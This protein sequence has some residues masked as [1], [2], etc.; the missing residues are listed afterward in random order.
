MAA[1]DEDLVTA[2]RALDTLVTADLDGLG[3]DDLNAGVLALQG[4]RCQVEAAEARLL[5]RWDANR[6][7]QPDGAKTGAAWLAWKQHLPITEARRR[8]RHARALRD[9]PAIEQAWAAGEIDRTHL[10]TMFSKRTPRTREAFAREHEVLLDAAR[11][12]RFTEFKRRCDRWELTVDP[13]G[14]EQGADADRR[15]RE[16]HLSQSFQGMWFGRMTFDP[17]SG[18]ILDTTLKMI[19]RELFDADS[20]DAR[21]RLGR[22][23][24][25]TELARTPAQRRAD[26][27]VEMAIRARTAPADGRRPAPLF[28]IVCGLESFTGPI[29]ELFNRTLLT[30][31][32]A[33]RWLT[34]ADV[35]RIVFS[36]PSRVID[37]STT[38]RFFRG[39]LR[40]AIEV[41]DRTC[42]HPSC[43]EIPDRQHIDHIHEAAKGGPTTQTNG[44]PACAFHNLRR[45]HHPDPD[46][47]EPG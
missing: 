23:P 33:A 24:L 32:V 1:L 7:W 42:F 5:S 4:L 19:E 11:S 46:D 3:S 43:D 16:V 37:V 25:V 2:S 21:Q 36:S 39:A 12:Q 40:R 9:L 8:L 34:E 27:L 38:T 22:D 45:N 6:C 20:T 30:P 15:A 47:D 35:E 10:A 44:R 41:R 13:D 28:T 17:V 14:A 18:T 29:L 31:G 26:A